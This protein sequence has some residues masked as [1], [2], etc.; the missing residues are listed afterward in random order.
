MK[1]WLFGL[2]ALLASVGILLL[3]PTLQAAVLLGIALWAACRWYYYLFYVIEKYTDPSFKFAGV[4]A[5]IRHVF[6]RKK[7]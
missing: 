5:A 4:G 3:V 6:G 7:S 1:G 2:L